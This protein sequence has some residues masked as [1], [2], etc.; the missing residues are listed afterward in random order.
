VPGGYIPRLESKERE[1]WKFL[2]KQHQQERRFQPFQAAIILKLEEF[3]DACLP[4]IRTTTTPKE[5]TTKKKTNK[6]MKEM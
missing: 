1:C 5:K 2:D 3:H 4:K 6:K